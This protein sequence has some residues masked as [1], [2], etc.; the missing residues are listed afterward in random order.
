MLVDL[1][2]KLITLLVSTLVFILACLAAYVYGNHQ[3]VQ[4]ERGV[5]EGRE[6]QRANNV[7]NTAVT[8][9]GKV[10]E[11]VKQ[12]Q[13]IERKA[14]ERHEAALEE[15]RK[16]RNAYRVLVA[17]HGGLRIAA[18][19]CAG[20]DPVTTGPITSSPGS[21]DG[22]VTGTIAL[23]KEVDEDLQDS[24]DEAD[25]ILEQARTCQGWIRDQGFYGPKPVE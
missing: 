21:S 20:R 19:A 6:R 23:P 2:A 5:W 14:N 15:L 12:D 13:E 9:V 1:K 7:A 18:N 10:V 11:E 17:E 3:G 25:R 16:S 4:Q 8:H 22:T 24:A